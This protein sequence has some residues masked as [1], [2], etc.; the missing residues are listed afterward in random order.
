MTSCYFWFVRSCLTFENRNVPSG[1]CFRSVIIKQCPL[2]SALRLSLGRYVCSSY[3]QRSTVRPSDSARIWQ[4]PWSVNPLGW[5]NTYQNKDWVASSWQPL[6]C[7]LQAAQWFIVYPTALFSFQEISFQTTSKIHN[8][9]NRPNTFM[10][11][12][13]VP[14]C[15]VWHIFFHM[16]WLQAPLLQLHMQFL[17]RYLKVRVVTNIGVCF[18]FGVG[19]GSVKGVSSVGRFLYVHLPCLFYSGTYS[20]KQYWVLRYKHW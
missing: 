14:L 1:T 3:G 12:D 6:S 4:V 15:S 20:A 13:I 8:T 17:A 11:L 10:M 2:F 18:G 7:L 19:T 5:H 16:L 9:G